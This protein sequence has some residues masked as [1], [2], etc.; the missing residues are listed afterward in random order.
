MK[1]NIQINKCHIVTSTTFVIF[2]SYTGLKRMEMQNIN[3]PISM[4]KKKKFLKIT[5]LIFDAD[6]CFPQV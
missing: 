3:S 2:T 5:I 1:Y 6:G 4:K